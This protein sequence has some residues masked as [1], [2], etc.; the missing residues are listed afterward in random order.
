MGLGTPLSLA[1]ALWP[2]V[3]L[4]HSLFLLE[5]ETSLMSSESYSYDGRP[6]RRM[7]C[8]CWAYRRLYLFLFLSRIR[9]RKKH[10]DSA[11]FS[12]SQQG[13]ISAHKEMIKRVLFI[14]WLVVRQDYTE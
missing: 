8:L 13:V 1:S 3:E 10:P 7:F 5:K 14:A 9:A 6:A 12:Q 4:C 2:V 11:H